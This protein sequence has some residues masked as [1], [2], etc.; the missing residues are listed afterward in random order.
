MRGCLFR[1]FYM[2]AG[3]LLL[4]PTLS[5]QAGMTTSSETSEGPAHLGYSQDW[6][7]RHLLIP[8]IPSAAALSVGERDPRYIYNLMRRQTALENERLK[9]AKPRHHKRIDWAVSLENGHV[10]QN[11][12]PAKYEFDIGVENCSTDYV[13]FGLTVTSGTQA[14]LVGINN[15]YTEATPRCN[16][17]SPWVSF[18]YNT[19]THAGGQIATSP[20]LSTDGRKVAFVE[21]TNTASYFHVLVLPNPIP[22]PPSQ[23]GTVLSPQTPTSCAA[24]TTPGCMTT[25]LIES[26]ATNSNSSP[27][28]DYVSDTAYVGADNGVLYKILH[29]FGGAAPVLVNDPLNWPVTVSNPL[30]SN[31]VLTAP[32]EDTDAGRI[33]VGDG[34]GF[35][36]AVSLTNPL[37]SF[38]AQLTV[39]WVG[40]GPGTGVVDSPIVVND[41]ANSAI[42][43]VFVSTGCSIVLGIGG[44]YSQVPA[45]FTLPLPSIPATPWILA[46]EAAMGTAPPA[47]CIRGT[48][49]MLSG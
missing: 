20:V 10:P 9:S 33:F 18:A 21:S 46:L 28:V 7:S 12:F 6:S 31:T 25:L 27:W 16:G 19:V 42:D 43:Q 1:L 24:P 15:L 14:N 38:S 26:G 5:G 34:Y 29:V 2:V 39:G 36:Y 23:T 8:D 22:A 3:L 4:A 49:I 40:F 45:N 37:K 41:P 48:L 35:L 30:Q 13:V 11:Q 47:T 17:G 32:I 44:A